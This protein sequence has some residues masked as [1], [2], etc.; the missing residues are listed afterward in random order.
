VR[1]ILFCIAIGLASGVPAQA[2]TYPVGLYRA[3]LDRYLTPAAPIRSRTIDVVR[4]YATLTD[5][6]TGPRL[7]ATVGGRHDASSHASLELAA[8]GAATF[9]SSTMEV[10]LRVCSSDAASGWWGGLTVSD[11]VNATRFALF[12]VPGASPCLEDVAARARAAVSAARV[13]RIQLG[14]RRAGT[15]QRSGTWLNVR[16]VKATVADDAPPRVTAAAA[17][18]GSD[19]TVS[20][21]VDDLESG[22]RAVV[23]AVTGPGGFSAGTPSW[24]GDVKTAQTTCL[25]GQWTTACATRK[26]G[27]THIAL[28]GITGDYDVQVSARDGVGNGAT[29][30]T[31]VRVTF[32]PTVTS[33]PQ[34]R[35]TPQVGQAISIG[36]DAWA[37]APAAVQYAFYRIEGTALVLVAGPAGDPAYTLAPADHGRMIVGRAIAANGA[38]RA[39]ADSAPFGPVRAAAPTGGT[40]GLAGLP[41]TVDGELSVM[42][43]VWDN[44][45]APGQPAVTGVAWYACDNAGCALRGSGTTFSPGAG[46]VGRRIHADVTVANDGG[47]ATAPT[48][49]S[50]PVTAAPPRLVKPPAIVG[51]ARVAATLAAVPGVWNGGGGA[52]VVTT[53]WLACDRALAACSAAGT[54]PELPVG[55]NLLGARLR[56]RETADNGTAR[57]VALSAA[58]PPVAGAGV[59]AERGQGVVSVCLGDG[60]MTLHAALARLRVLAG[61]SV[62]VSGRVD[63]FGGVAPPAAVVVRLAPAEPYGAYGSVKRVAL[64]PDGS[65][66][67]LLQPAISGRV[68]I[69]T[70]VAGTPDALLLA[71]PGLRVRPRIAVAFTVRPDLYGRVRDLR[72]TGR[73]VPRVALDRFRLLLSGRLPD[74]T[75]VGLVCRV[76]EQPVVHRGRFAGGC[77]SRGLPRRARFR[78][79]FLAGPGSPLDSASSTWR[80]ARVR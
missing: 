65:F 3:D 34:V 71:L 30:V 37:N 75:V 46:D 55:E 39:S 50:D 40:P 79:T 49:D 56:I 64:G 67:M 63:A 43:G 62:L 10:A 68:E 41:A 33:P 28:P 38:G 9:V 76:M 54:G 13:L 27:A 11:G 45:G 24:S 35:G 22:P 2:G 19:L 44:G 6:W 18:A 23:V 1:R 69:S 74:G 52:V 60:R 47:S 14:A 5:G 53:E 12:D 26:T 51:D 48:P 73:V 70:A 7:R 78:V 31:R 32:A 8:P 61:R 42:P 66:R 16:S 15:A 29:A 59:C 17:A 4:D 77:R 36:G 80:L 58:T 72:F 25:S 57:T 20:W 21:S